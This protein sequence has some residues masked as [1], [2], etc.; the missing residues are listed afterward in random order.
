[1]SRASFEKM[2]EAVNIMKRLY[3]EETFIGPIKAGKKQ[4]V[5]PTNRE[6]NMAAAKCCETL[7]DAQG[8]FRALQHANNMGTHA[9]HF[10]ELEKH[11]KISPNAHS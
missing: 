8:L 2:V 3:K 4:N 5:V 11:F 7:S 1:M 9:G 6:Q 10:E